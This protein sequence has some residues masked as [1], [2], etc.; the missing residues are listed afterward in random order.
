MQQTLTAKIRLYPT[1][2]QIALFKAVT[3]EYQRLCNIVSQWYFDGHF[4][5]NQKV[6][7]KDMYR[8]LQNESPKL[9]S[10]MVQSTYRTVKARYDTV[11][12]QLYQHP[13]R[14]DTGLIDEKTGK[15]VWK[16]VPRT[17]EWL[18]K[19]IHFKRPQA[20][21]VHGSNY[22]LVKER[23]M[24]SLNVL[25]KRIKVPF[26]ADYLE[27]L[28][29]TNAKLGTAKLVQLK[30]HWFLHVPVT[31][32][33]NEWEKLRNRH[34]VGIDRGLR[35]IMTIYD[36]QGKTK[37]FNGNRVAYQ[38]KKYAHLRKQLQA[39]GTKSAKRHLK[40]LAGR[41]NRWMED[42]NHRLSKTLVQHY[43]ENTLFVLEDLTNVSFD[44][45]NQSTRDHNRDLHSW[46]FY[47]LQVKLTYKAQANQS[48]VLMA[49]A[50]YTSQRCP[51]CGQI[52]KENRNHALHR[53]DCAN[54]GFR[55]NDD[56]VGAMNLYKLGKQ[57]LTGNERP[58]FELNNVAD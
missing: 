47:D 46:P 17:L 11:R 42:V 45:K 56:R 20:D 1:Y 54:C 49:S 39:T 12:T 51:K 44:E 9:N 28:F 13:Y 41:E 52:R 58:K 21:Y 4:N 55:T 22:S 34:I 27:D 7:Q 2:E 57:Y 6:F 43:G 10:Q 33:V 15:H 37:F 30:K 26:K 53:Y 8:Y 3:K 29:T 40:R 5:A 48:Q 36:E 23:T 16:S 19:P 14:Y 31:I 18:W 25:A 38:R 35:Q 24:I 32:E 50:K